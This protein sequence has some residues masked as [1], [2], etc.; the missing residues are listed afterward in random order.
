MTATGRCAAATL[1][2]VSIS[3]ATEPSSDPG[4]VAVI[5]VSDPAAAH[6]GSV[7]VRGLGSRRALALE[8]AANSTE[9]PAALEVFTGAAFPDAADPDAGLGQSGLPKAGLPEGQNALPPVLGDL[10]A[11]GDRLRFTPRY[12]FVPGQPYTARWR[13]VDAPGEP[14]S[15]PPSSIL[16]SFSLSP[17]DAEPTTAVAQVYPTAEVLPE[18]LLKFYLHFSASMSRGNASAHIRLLDDEGRELPYPFVAPHQELWNKTNDR[19][20]LILDPGRIKR[21]VGPNLEMGPPLVAGRSFRLVIDKAWLDG[22]GLPMTHGFEKRFRVTDPDR[23]S[24]RVED[25]RLSAPSSPTAPL[26]VRFP[27]P[28]DHALLHRLLRVFDGSGNPVEGTLETQDHQQVWNFFPNDPWSQESYELRAASS[29]ED[30][31]GNTFD[32]TFDT[33]LE[34]TPS[35]EEPKGGFISLTFQPVSSR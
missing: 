10:V 7:E 21:N 18:N 2:L 30:L 19:L 3:C 26:V 4:S 17:S 1:L 28:F 20:T 12:P 11:D 32:G 33:S 9:G 8:R 13:P 16:L 6:F 22:Q 31:A 34:G 35:T 23:L 27:E 5:F 29:L 14:I 24:P 25:W 15:E